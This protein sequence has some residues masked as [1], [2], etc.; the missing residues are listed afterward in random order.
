MIPFRF[1][2]KRYPTGPGCYVLRNARGAVLYVG[3]AKN[4][5]RRLVSH[6]NGQPT[7]RRWQRVLAIVADIELILV[8]NE[9]EA[10]ILESN[11]IKLHQPPANR[12]LLELDEGYFYIALT[13]EDLPRLVPYRKHRINKQLER[14][15]TVTDVARC[16]GPYV[17][18]RYRDALLDFVTEQ[19]RLRTCSPLSKEV[20]LRFHM[21]TCGGI[22]EHRVSATDYTR[23]VT[24]AIRFLSR[25][26]SD[27]IRQMRRRMAACA[28]ALQFEQAGHIKRHLQL[29]EAA[30]EPQVV[31][32]EVRHD[33]DVLHFD[34][35]TVL[36]LHVR[37]GKV[38]GCELWP[39]NGAAAQQFILDRYSRNCPSELIVNNLEE[40]PNVERQLS[41]PGGPH[42]RI[43]IAGT[44]RRAADR[45]MQL[46]V[47]NHAYRL[48][49]LQRV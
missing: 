49:L 10:L 20:C 26:H 8:S 9:T 11:L 43:A 18:R 41:T 45:L 14:G 19:H 47:L 27:L 15:T 35:N 29:L 46:A 7:S 5:R 48:S 21:G 1:D 44:G 30:L 13:A 28:A 12:V 3:K 36:A 32:R 39:L 22:C 40:V 2:A 42:V 33:Q 38:C 37:A 23:A 4:L 24:D 17:N 34:A 6:F 31:E 25:P 16:F